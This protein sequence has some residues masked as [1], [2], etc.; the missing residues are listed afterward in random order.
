MLSIIFRSL[1]NPLTD[2]LV[3]SGIKH[4]ISTVGVFRFICKTRFHYFHS[5]FRIMNNLTRIYR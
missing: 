4:S 5:I 1:F 3:F 2:F